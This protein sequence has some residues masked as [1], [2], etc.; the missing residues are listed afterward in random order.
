[1]YFG[2]KDVPIC[3]APYKKEYGVALREKASVSC[4][5]DAYPTDVEFKWTFNSSS[6]GR[7]TEVSSHKKGLF[8]VVDH[9]PMSEYDYGQ[10][11]CYA[12]NDIGFQAEPCTFNIVHASK[13]S[14][15]QSS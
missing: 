2:K 6:T 12:K 14:T 15:F 5:V 10:L 8:S 11:N 9:F 1:M 4:Q 3:V 7:V 13:S